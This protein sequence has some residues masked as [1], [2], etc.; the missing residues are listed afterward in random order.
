MYIYKMFSK[1]LN[2]LFKISTDKSIM[3]SLIRKMIRKPHK[4]NKLTT[5]NPIYK[6]NKKSK[7]IVK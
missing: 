3:S 7:K 2:Y 1:T 4:F 5:Y 6:P